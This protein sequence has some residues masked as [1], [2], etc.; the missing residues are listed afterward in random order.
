[1][2]YNEKINCNRQHTLLANFWNTGFTQVIPL[3]H[4]KLPPTKNDQE[5]TVS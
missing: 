2:A 3:Y 5:P 4:L 1:M